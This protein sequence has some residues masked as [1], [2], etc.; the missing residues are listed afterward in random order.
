M[1]RL[2]TTVMSLAK[3]RH[4]ILYISADFTRLTLS[5]PA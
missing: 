5:A 3:A 2:A 1:K 4:D